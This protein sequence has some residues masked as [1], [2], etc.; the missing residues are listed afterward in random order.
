[1][2]CSTA[3]ENEGKGWIVYRSNASAQ[4]AQEYMDGGQIDGAVISVK[5]EHMPEE[6]IDRQRGHQ[7]YSKDNARYHESQY[8]RDGQDYSRGSR[9][10]RGRY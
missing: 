7:G 9:R 8:G 10:G 6:H 1:M 5:Q 4:K 2:I 3:G